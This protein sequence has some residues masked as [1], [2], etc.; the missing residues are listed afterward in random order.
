MTSVTIDAGVKPLPA[1]HYRMLGLLQS[2]W[3]K[4]RTVRSTMWTLGVIV[5]LGLGLSALACAETQAHW[6]TMNFAQRAT[7]DPTQTSLIGIAFGQLVIGILGV[8]VMSAEYSTGTIRATLSAAPRRAKV[9]L[10]KVT[11]FAAVALVVAEVVS[12]ASY[13]LGQ[14][15]LTA[16]ATHTSLGDPGALRAVAGAGLYLCVLG[17]FALGLATIIRHTAGAIS[18]FVGTLL[19]LPLIIAALPSS[20]GNDIRPFLPANIGNSITALTPGSHSFAPW[21][22][23]A[24]LCG[25]AAV[26]LVIGGVL[27]LR[28]DA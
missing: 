26:T 12:F 21:T 2:E 15:L 23:F 13:F 4:L 16:P 25:Y 14:A 5:L 18:A 27:L 11:V 3:T 1:G 10:A 6:S 7:F 17:L 19:V 9:L 22:G 24:W 20:I 8:L 28:R